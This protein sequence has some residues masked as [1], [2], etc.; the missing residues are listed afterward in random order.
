MSIQSQPQFSQQIGRENYVLANHGALTLQHK[1]GPIIELFPTAIIEPIRHMITQ[2]IYRGKLPHRLSII[3]AMQEEGVTFISRAMAAS[4]AHDTGRSVCIVDLNWWSPNEKST[5]LLN[6]HPGITDILYNK[7]SLNDAL[8][9]TTNPYLDMLLPGGVDPRQRPILSRDTKLA[10]LLTQ[11]SEQFDH[12]LLDIPAIKSTS[13]SI[14]LASLG[15]SCCMV[16]RHG[17][18]SSNVVGQ[19]LSEVEHIPIM[20]VLMNR[21]DNKT[22]KW[23]QNVIPQN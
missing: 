4:L 13:D 20:G 18:T 22:P 14:A 19:V 15:D 21:V 2:C 16:V 6:D 23:I 17:A 10:D 7:V 11:L 1:R 12:L 9:K 8:V 5:K 3:S